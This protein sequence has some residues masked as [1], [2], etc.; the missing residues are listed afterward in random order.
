MTLNRRAL[1]GSLAVAGVA[2]CLGDGSDDTE[3]P[4]ADGAVLGPP[5]ET[6]GDASHP[7]YGDSIL[8]FELPDPHA[9]ELVT[10]E[11][12]LEDGPFVLTFIYTSC[13][14]QCG[15][16]MGLLELVQ[17]D[18]IEEGWIDDVNLV[19]M[20]FDPEVDGPDTLRAYGEM[21]GLDVDDSHFR[22]LR[23]ESPDEAIEIVSDHFGVPAEH[24]DGE[25]AD[26]VEPDDL[27][28]VH[29]YMIFL[30]N[31]DGIVERS[32][33][34]PILFDRSANEFVE[35]VRMVVT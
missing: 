25:P 6:R 21:H 16:L 12:L 22:F 3:A 24:H 13:T 14:G 27:G 32:Y 19:A 2:G 34:G 10:E 7:T 28:V 5:D 9:G 15:E 18:A 33:P 23:P 35:D 17:N 20:T 1:L 31:G 26:D 30:V 4:T 29:Y 11:D 8:S